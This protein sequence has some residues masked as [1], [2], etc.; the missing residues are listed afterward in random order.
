M[1]PA[2]PPPGKTAANNVAWCGKCYNLHAVSDVCLM[3]M[4]GTRQ[5]PIFPGDEYFPTA[6]HPLLS[7]HTT[8]PP[9]LSFLERESGGQ[10]AG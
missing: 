6:P 5:R 4:Y 7:T 3:S 9:P 2:A 1:A 8:T 10:K